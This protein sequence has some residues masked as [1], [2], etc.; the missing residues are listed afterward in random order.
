MN[1]RIAQTSKGSLEYT[2]RGDGPVV[3]VCHGT[4]SDCRSTS[5]SHTLMEAG[6]TVLTPSRPGYGRTPLR[7]GMTAQQAAGALVALLDHLEIRACAVLAVSGG[8]PTGVALA[9]GFPGQVTRL[10]LAEAITCPEERANEPSYR[11]Q[12]AFYGPRHSLTWAMLRLASN[13][14]PRNMARQTMAIFS[15]HDPDDALAQL[16][17]GDIAAI[18][19]FYQGRS[20]RAGALNDLNHT[21]GP[22]VLRS[23]QQPTLVIH[24]RQDRSVPFSH[25]EWALKHLARAT[26]YEAGLTGHFYWVGP[27][28]LRVSQHLAGFLKGG[29]AAPNGSATSRRLADA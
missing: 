23:V 5:G 16:S 9:A 17:A 27:D 8:G 25:A 6:F 26:L 2:L 28:S 10:A 24:S 12:V 11:S 4:S 14:G 22:A 15:T 20:S 13:L 3:L 1:S 18:R 21:V 29:D 7:V 19:Q